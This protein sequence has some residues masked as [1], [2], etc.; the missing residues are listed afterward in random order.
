MAAGCAT[1]TDDR[2]LVRHQFT[3]EMIEQYRADAPETLRARVETLL[4]DPDR[5]DAMG[6]A[7]RAEV[8]RG[9]L[10]DHRTDLIGKVLQSV[11]SMVQEKPAHPA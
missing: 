3:Q 7:G 6:R 1:I 4:G 2:P 11:L 10:W 8:Q 5:C 9:H